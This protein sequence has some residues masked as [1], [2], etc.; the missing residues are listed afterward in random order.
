MA[1]TKTKENNLYSGVIDSA[2]KLGKSFAPFKAQSKKAVDLS[3]FQN[4]SNVAGNY[5][6]PSSFKQLGAITTPYGGSTK[7]EGSHPGIDIA[8]KI[9]TPI[10]AF[11]GGTV[12]DV[13]GGFKQGDQGFGNSVIIKDSQGNMVRYSHLHNAYVKVGQQINPGAVI[14]SMGNSGSTYSTSGGTGSHLDLRIKDAQ[15]NYLD[16]NKYL[17]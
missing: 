14:G 10:S 8:N 2:M 11:T 16:P 12:I 3:K 9:G 4:V 5:R 13:Q 15:G 1:G 17:S 7:F 6:T